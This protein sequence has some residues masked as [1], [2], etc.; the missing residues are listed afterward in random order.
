[1]TQIPS[2][3]VAHVPDPLPAELPVLDVREPHEWEAGH[4]DGAVHVPLG[5]LSDRLGEV[6]TARPLLVTCKAGGRSAKA[7]EFLTAQGY[8][9]V[10]LDGGMLAWEQAARPMVSETAEDPRVV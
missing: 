5:E 10:N 1:M 2:T 3:D 4:I 6:P 8:D 7:V 9:A